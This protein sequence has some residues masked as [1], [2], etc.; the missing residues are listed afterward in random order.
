[1]NKR[2]IIVS[3]GLW[4]QYTTWRNGCSLSDY[5]LEA[6][7]DWLHFRLYSMDDSPAVKLIPNI[8]ACRNRCCYLLVVTVNWDSIVLSLSYWSGSTNKLQN[9]LAQ[10]LFESSKLT[11]Q[12]N[13]K[14]YITTVCDG[15]SL[16]L[17]NY[18]SK[19]AQL[20][21][22]LVAQKD[23]NIS[24]EASTTLAKIQ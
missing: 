23:L 17:R 14:M 24:Y 13:E 19:N 20:E 7:M 9:Q 1:M 5:D 12:S 2:L 18:K 15:L 10:G 8:I 3:A 21:E 6:L 4:A 11:S 16:R 22:L